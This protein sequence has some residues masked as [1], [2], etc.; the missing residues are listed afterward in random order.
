MHE[1]VSARFK[2]YRQDHP[3]DPLPIL[4]DFA[5]RVDAAPPSPPCAP[6]G[7]RI[8]NIARCAARRT[9]AWAWRMDSAEKKYIPG[10]LRAAEAS[11]LFPVR[12]KAQGNSGERAGAKAGEPRLLRR[13]AKTMFLKAVTFRYGL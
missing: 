3:G 8:A 9:P 11:R 12:K 4:C 5:T 1:R 10:G 6:L 13:L 2:R 7:N